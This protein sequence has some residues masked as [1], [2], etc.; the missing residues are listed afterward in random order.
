MIADEMRAWLQVDHVGSTWESHNG[1]SID[2]D[3]DAW[4]SVPDQDCPVDVLPLPTAAAQGGFGTFGFTNDDAGNA[5]HGDS[6][7]VSARAWSFEFNTPVPDYNPDDPAGWVARMLRERL[8]S[9]HH[10]DGS[11][12]QVRFRRADFAPGGRRCIQEF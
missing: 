12:L 3:Y 6:F 2:S 7:S 5:K 1:S 9:H 4:L 11:Q 8:D 10:R